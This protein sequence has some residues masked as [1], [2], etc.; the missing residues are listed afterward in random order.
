MCHIELACFYMTSM[1]L[2]AFVCLLCPVL[3]YVSEIKVKQTNI[4]TTLTHS[5]TQ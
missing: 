2:H 4:Q 3:F 1:G 5:V